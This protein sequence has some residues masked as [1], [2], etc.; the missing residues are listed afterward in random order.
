MRT[1]SWNGQRKLYFKIA[2]TFSW[3]RR[4]K[5]TLQFQR[6]EKSNRKNNNSFCWNI[7]RLNFVVYPS[8][9]S[10]KSTLKKRRE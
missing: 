5:Q 9:S 1:K 6:K 2:I 7:K 8:Y 10:G 4:R 3:T